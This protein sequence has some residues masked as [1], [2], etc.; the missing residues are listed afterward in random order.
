MPKGSNPHNILTRMY[1]ES[2]RLYRWASESGTP[3]QQ[4]LALKLSN[5]HA[6]M[7]TAFF[8]AQPPSAPI[9]TPPKLTPY[10]LGAQAFPNY[11]NPFL[12]DSMDWADYDRG[13]ADNSAA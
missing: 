7:S 9:E 10:E 8:P 6:H 2:H 12:A 11:D 4:A 13:F 3:E 5:L 1:V